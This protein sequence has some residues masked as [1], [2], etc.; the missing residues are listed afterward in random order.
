MYVCVCNAVTE[1]DIKNA[2]KDGANCMHHLESKL[3]VSGNCGSCRCEAAACLQRSLE[4][5]M[6]STDLIANF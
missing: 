4:Q 5:E 1:S 6:G 3:G 2:V